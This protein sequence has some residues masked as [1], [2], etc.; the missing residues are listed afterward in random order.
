MFL[1]EFEMETT[2]TRESKTG[3]EHTYTRRKRIAVFRCDNC[4]NEFTRD[5]GSMS[6]KRLNNNYFHV[7]DSCD[8]KRFAQKRGVER[9]QVW[10]LTASSNIPISKL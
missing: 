3:V 5:R 4:N 6:P 10:N 2:Y 7:C 9:K 8:S 1:R